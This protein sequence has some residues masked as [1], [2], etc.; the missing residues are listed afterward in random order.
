M[1]LA[2]RRGGCGF[3]CA[4]RWLLGEVS[5][6]ADAPVACVCGSG[7]SVC[8][9]PDLTPGARQASMLPSR[10]WPPQYTITLSFPPS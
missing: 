7:R 10:E 1:R 9:L 8:G 6:F 5:P 4:S 3:A 2:S